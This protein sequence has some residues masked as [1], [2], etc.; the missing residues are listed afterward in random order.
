VTGTLSLV[1]SNR[2]VWVAVAIRGLLW[3]KVEISTSEESWTR[4][5]EEESPA[6][7]SYALALLMIDDHAKERVASWFAEGLRH[8]RFPGL[9]GIQGSVCLASVQGLRCSSA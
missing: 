4:T 2:S 1:P 9:P 7:E 3:P 8:G 5:F 6:G